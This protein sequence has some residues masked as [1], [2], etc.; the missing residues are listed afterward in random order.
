MTQDEY[1]NLLS[2]VDGKPW[3]ARLKLSE[4]LKTVTIREESKETRTGAQ[5]RSLHLGCRLI[6]DALNDAGLDIRTVLKPEI[7][8]PWDTHTVKEYIFRPVMKL[9]RNTESTT[10]LK[11]QGDIDAIWETVMRFLMQNHHIDYIPFPNDPT[12]NNVRLSAIDNLSNEHY[13]E[14]TESTLADKF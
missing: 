8:M 10:T 5:N 6:A 3:E 7:E 4:Y 1:A 12:K 2:I 13:P 9:M 14:M 11:K